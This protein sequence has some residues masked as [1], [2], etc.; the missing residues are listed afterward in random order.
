MTNVGDPRI[1]AYYAPLT[2]EQKKAG[3]YRDVVGGMW[4]EIGGLQFDFLVSHGL[5]PGM[6]FL[7]IGC[8]SFRGGIHFIKYLNSGNYYGVDVN[9]SLIEAGYD[10]ELKP[11]GLDAKVPG[12][13]LLVSSEFDF[14]KLD[15]TFD[16]ALAMS[17]FTHLPLNHIRVCLAKLARSIKPGGAFFATYFRCPEDRSVELALEHKPGGVVTYPDRDPYHY[18]ESDF[19]WIIRSLGW[20]L[21]H[22]GDFGHPRAQRM[23]RFEKE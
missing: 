7:D 22:I 1:N 23:A 19:E 6:K 4:D 15:V 14:G 18:H 2:E 10:L 8:G 21:T 16:M 9:K 12:K 20:N 3:F 17:V 13:N 11:A 5:K